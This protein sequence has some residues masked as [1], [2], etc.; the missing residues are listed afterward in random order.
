MKKS[1]C[2]LLLFY[3]YRKPPPSLGRN[4]PEGGVVCTAT[5]AKKALIGVRHRH[6]VFLIGHPPR[7]KTPFSPNEAPLRP[8]TIRLRWEPSTSVPRGPRVGTL[9]FRMCERQLKKARERVGGGDQG[10][11]NVCVVSDRRMSASACHDIFFSRCE[12]FI[13]RGRA[14]LM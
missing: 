5:S 9:V 14:V 8:Q 2:S 7:G 4:C 12:G 1:E 6:S 11:S 13:E 3:V 10:Q